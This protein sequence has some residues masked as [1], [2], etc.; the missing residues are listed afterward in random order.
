[1]TLRLNFGSRVSLPGRS[2]LVTYPGSKIMLKSSGT[3]AER[4]CHELIRQGGTHHDHRPHP[5]HCACRHFGRRN[6]WAVVATCRRARQ[7]WKHAL[8][9]AKADAGIFMMV[10]NRGFAE[11]QGL[12]LEIS[13]FK[14]DQIAPQ[15][16]D[17]RR[18]RQLRRRAAGR[19]RGRSPAAPTSSII[20]C[21]WVVVPHGIYAETTSQRVADLKGKSIAVSAPNSMPDMLARSR[22]RNTASRRPT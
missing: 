5:T 14:D 18:G 20:G 7:A 13:Q 4:A 2:V 19:F 10:A 12:K 3:N 15:G 1:M 21:H 6:D 11:K 22:W 17:R 8:I 16:A 9:N